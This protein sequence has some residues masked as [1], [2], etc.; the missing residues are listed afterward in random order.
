MKKFKLIKEYP[1]SPKLGQIALPY[2][3]SKNQIV[4]YIVERNQKNDCDYV[5]I[6]KKHVEDNPD[7]WQE[8][9]SLD[10]QMAKTKSI[11]E[12]I[13]LLEKISI[14]FANWSMS[15]NVVKNAE[16]YFHFSDK[17]M[18]DVFKKEKGL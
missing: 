14:E 9:K 15:A 16:K 3:D 8:V 5:A 18:F 12:A 1:G 2:T 6:P 11:E 17:D 7:Y 10:M 4:H 13:E